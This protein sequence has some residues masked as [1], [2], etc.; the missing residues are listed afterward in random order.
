LVAAG[1]PKHTWVT[2]IDPSPH[3][4]G[5]ALAAFDGHRTGDRAVH[6]YRTSDY[7]AT[8]E[9]ISTDDIEGYALSVRQ[10][11]VNPNL[12]F[13]GTEFG[14]YVSP[15]AGDSWARFKG[16]LPRVGVR[17]IQ[18]HPREHDLIL[19]THGR[20]IQIIDDITPLRY[21]TAETMDEAG[22]LLPSRQQYLVVPTQQ[23]S[24]NGDNEFVASASPEGAMIS[25]YLKKRHMFGDLKIEIHDAEGNW[26]TTLPTTKR[27]GVN[28]VI[29]SLRGRAPKVPPAAS[30]VPQL[31][32]LLGPQVAA[33]DYNVTLVRGKERYEQ[34]LNVAPNPRSGYSAEEMA[35]QDAVV[36]RVY[37]LV[38]RLTFLVDRL[39]EIRDQSTEHG[40][41][42]K[43]KDKLKVN[44]DSFV[45]ELETFRATLVATRKGGFIAG[46][47]QL[48]ERLTSLYG[49]VNG[50][51][52]KPSQQHID[53]ADLIQIEVEAAEDRLQALFDGSIESLNRQL[54]RKGKTALADLS[55]EAWE[56]R[57]RR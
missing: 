8:W 36:A 15:N 23:Q 53:Y 45:Q 16:D 39:I 26:I 30:L 37:T 40:D 54:A 57:Q 25:Y 33:G 51:E 41:S 50:Y 6:L 20:G 2:G 56:A 38:E 11:L 12:Y 35:A 1:L 10:D 7:G 19:G 28:R 22:T 14:L 29:W 34:T 49:S 42:L 44:L 32:S 21:L 5:S 52:G 3:Q 17:E 43:A 48:R 18:I 24:F 46:E 55:A 47:E 27:R 31:F 4:E 9:S 13:V